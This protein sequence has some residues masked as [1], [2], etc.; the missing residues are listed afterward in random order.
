MDGIRS[1][2]STQHTDATT[3]VV[4]NDREEQC[5]VDWL[6]PLGYLS[7]LATGVTQAAH[8]HPSPGYISGHL[9]NSFLFFC[10]PCLLLTFRI[11]FCYFLYASKARSEEFLI[12]FAENG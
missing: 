4:L 12:L 9:C 5:S 11:T 7:S 3:D 6:L 1:A 8:V 10:D 2:T